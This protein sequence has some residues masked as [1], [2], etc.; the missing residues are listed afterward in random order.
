MARFP[1]Q[2]LLDHALH[3]LEAAERLLRLLRKKEADA[4]AQLDALRSYRTEYQ[5]Q[6]GVKGG[7]GLPIHLLRD[8]HGF[9]GKMEEAVMHQELAVEQTRVNLKRGQTQWEE[10]RRKVKA[11]Q[12]MADRHAARERLK[13]DRRDQRNMDEFASRAHRL[14]KED[15]QS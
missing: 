15:P 8:Y 10:Q 3:R 1:L 4:L 6:Y 5:R 7:G 14:Q 12:A 2:S 13:E 9:L 11:Y